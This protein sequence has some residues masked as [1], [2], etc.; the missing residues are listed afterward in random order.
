MHTYYAYYERHRGVRIFRADGR[1]AGWELQK[2]VDDYSTYKKLDHVLAM[3]TRVV[4]V[5]TYHT[6]ME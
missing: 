2:T 3:H 4:V 1:V 5:A 6:T